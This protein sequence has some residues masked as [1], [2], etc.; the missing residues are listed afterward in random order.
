MKKSKLQ[1]VMHAVVAAL[2]SLITIF[3]T[4]VGAFAWT[5]DGSGVANGGGGKGG[6]GKGGGKG[7]V[8]LITDI[9]VDFRIAC[10]LKN[11]LIVIF[12]EFSQNQ[13]FCFKCDSTFVVGSFLA[14][15]RPKVFFTVKGHAA[16]DFLVIAV[17]CEHKSAVAKHSTAV[18]IFHRMTRANAFGF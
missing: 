8:G 6:G 13:P 16:V 15:F 10:P 18:G 7:F 14:V 11:I 9:S 4:T 5:V 1:K 17:F 2:L 3:S 12:L